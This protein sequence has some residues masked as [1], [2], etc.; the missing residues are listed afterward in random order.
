VIEEIVVKC[1]ENVRKTSAL[2]PHGGGLDTGAPRRH[3]RR[4]EQ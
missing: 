1:V 4:I 3:L 2:A